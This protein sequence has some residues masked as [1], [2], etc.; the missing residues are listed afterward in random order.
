MVGIITY[1]ATGR[2]HQPT[3]QMKSKSVQVCACVHRVYE[4]LWAIRNMPVK[5]FSV[6]D[7]LRFDKQITEI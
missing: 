5:K 6:K 1:H 2:H 7:K 4:C 3:K